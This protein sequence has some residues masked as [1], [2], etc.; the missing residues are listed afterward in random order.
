MATLLVGG[1]AFVGI[2]D[3]QDSVKIFMII[4]S[5]FW[6]V[7][8]FLYAQAAT[9]TFGS[10]NSRKD[11]QEVTSEQAVPAAKGIIALVRTERDLI[12]WK[13][14]QANISAFLAAITSVCVIGLMW[15]LDPATQSRAVVRIDSPGVSEVAA[16]CDI[17][18]RTEFTATLD[19]TD[20]SKT[21]ITL[22]DIQTRDCKNASELTIPT[23]WVA[24][25]AV[26]P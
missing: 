20:L 24:I 23:K 14:K 9:G 10:T 4:A 16:V 21:F 8:T 11:A 17:R 26:Q 12:R 1:A 2:T 5:V 6:L 18:P 13:T 19:L 25:V 7:A 22:T 3:Q 15:L